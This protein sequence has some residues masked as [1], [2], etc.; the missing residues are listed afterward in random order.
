MRIVVLAAC[1]FVLGAAPAQGRCV[2]ADLTVHWSGQAD[3]PVL[4][5]GQCLVPTPLPAT[6]QVEED[7]SVPTPTGTPSGAYVD[8]WVPMP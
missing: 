6:F 1:A 8:L 7:R 3:Q 2:A 4:T 5:D